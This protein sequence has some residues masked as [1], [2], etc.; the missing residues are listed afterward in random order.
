MTRTG[1]NNTANLL[2][3][4]FFTAGFAVL[5]TFVLVATGVLE[6]EPG[7]GTA[8]IDSRRA[9]LVGTI[10][11]A[12][13]AAGA[14]AIYRRLF[15]RSSSIPVFFMVLFFIF[16]VGD[17]SK[18]G[19][20]LIPAPS[21]R[22]LSPLLARFTIFSHIAGAL[23]FFAAGLYASVARMQRQGT[24][25]LLGTLIALGLSWAVPIDTLQLPDNLVY[26]AGFRASLDAAIMII[27]ALGVL[28]FIQAA[29][30]G[31]DRRQAVSAIAA[32]FIAI[33][34]EVLF[35][36]AEVPLIVIGTGLFAAGA[37][38]FAVQNY[39]DYL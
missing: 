27:L 8:R 26:A 35:Y 23:S 21:W 16:T 34:R 37:G 20:V 12:T 11:T 14:A 31:R 22:H 29:A 5:A 33:G 36:R 30:A 18:L 25:I 9:A 19:H 2:L 3:A 38:V 1:R 32:A 39:R 13:V 17:I 15:R 28:N 10:L 4:L 7:A 6:T 24:A